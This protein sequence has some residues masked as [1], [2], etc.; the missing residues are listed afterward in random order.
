[1]NIK[2]THFSYCTNIHPAETWNETFDSLKHFLPY[3]KGK[4]SP[5]S[6]FGC[7]LRISA[8]ASSEII[9]ES[10]FQEFSEWLKEN[11]LY[12]FTL[13]GFPY[14]NFHG[15]IVKD[16]VHYPDWTHIDRANYTKQL[17]LILSKLLP[18]GTE[19]GISTSP[20]TYRFWYKN[21]ATRSL[22]VSQSLEHL[23]S[24]ILFLHQVSET[25]GAVIH[26]DIEPEPDG[27]LENSKEF[28]GWYK[29][30]LLT[31]GVNLITSA[32]RI[33]RD[34][35]EIIIRRHIRLCYDTCHFALEFE[36]PG[37]VINKLRMEGL[38]I[39]KV[40][41]SSA[42]KVLIPSSK[43]KDEVVK[44]LL[45]F[46][47]SNYLH[48]VRIKTVEGEVIKIPDLEMAL[49][50]PEKLPVGELRTHFHVPVFLENYG[51]LS[52][53]REE[54]EKTFASITREDCDHFE[55]E[56]YTWGVLP[57]D[58]KGDL[59]DFIIK[60]LDWVKPLVKKIRDEENSC[61]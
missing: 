4:V 47:E 11:N 52:S 37:A 29:E 25:S 45:P 51:I 18:E 54:I 20:L 39:G 27:L 59:K 46:A 38:R 56:T 30:T 32:L 57:F 14:G 3:I 33:S 31:A 42:L 17:A 16:R 28:I 48:Q 43:G 7:G 26:L 36:E 61:Y 19:G 23:I 40:Q 44:E 60:E 13:N 10:V 9:S 5:D 50:H 15:T 1:M 8:Q 22:A 2:G 49:L 35:A 34:Q 55:V 53:T 12:I 6:P 58:L 41:V 24:V 21:K